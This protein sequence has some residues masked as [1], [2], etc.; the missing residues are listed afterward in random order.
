VV[1]EK[2]NLLVMRGWMTGGVV[3]EAPVVA[4]AGGGF[5]GVVRFGVVQ[6]SKI[7]M[8][9]SQ[10]SRVAV[11]GGLLTLAVSGFAQG[12]AGFVAQAGEYGVSGGLAGDQVQ[13]QVALRPAGGYVVWEDAWG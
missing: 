1:V 7:V 3:C 10:W 8:A 4:G 9:F 13:P 11:C 12:Q 6:F 2:L 5:F